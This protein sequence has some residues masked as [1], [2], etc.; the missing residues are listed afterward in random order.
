MNEFLENRKS[1]RDFKSKNLSDSDLKKV[2]SIIFE[3]NNLAK[4]YDV[5]FKLYKDGSVVYNA[6]DGEGGYEGT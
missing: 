1:V 6:L 5:N 4:K 2:E 3:I